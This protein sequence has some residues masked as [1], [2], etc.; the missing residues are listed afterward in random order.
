MGTTLGKTKMENPSSTA[1]VSSHFRALST[2]SLFSMK[3]QGISINLHI[4]KALQLQPL[5]RITVDV[6]KCHQLH[7]GS[8]LPTEVRDQD[9]AW[10]REG[11]HLYDSLSD[12]AGGPDRG[13]FGQY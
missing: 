3:V 12:F 6:A 1:A 13:E 5:H 4:K 7:Q 8:E 9:R 10:V 2:L 11:L